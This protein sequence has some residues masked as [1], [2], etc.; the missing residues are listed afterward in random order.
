MEEVKL[1][2]EYFSGRKLI[3]GSEPW[4]H[5]YGGHQFGYFAGQL[6]D[7]RAISLGQYK[8]IHDQVWELQLKGSGRTPYSRFGDGYAVWRSSVR[9]FLC[10]E[11]FHALGIPTSRAA[12]MIATGKPVQREIMEPG[13]IVTRLAP[14]WIRF[15]SFELWVARQDKVNLEKLMKYTQT[16]FYPWTQDYVDL[17]QA[18]VDR[19]L[20]T[21]TQWQLIGWAHGV[22]NTD[23]ISIIGL[24]LDYGPFAFLDRFD[25][26]HVSNH[27][28]ELGRYTLRQQPKVMEW[29]L[30]R[31]AECFAFL[32]NDATPFLN[33]LQKLPTT[34]DTMYTQGLCK[35]LG[36][37]SEQPDDKEKFVTPFLALMERHGVDYTHFFRQLNAW[38]PV[39]PTPLFPLPDDF[40]LRYAHR[41]LQDWEGHG[42]GVWLEAKRKHMDGINPN[43]VFR[44]WMTPYLLQEVGDSEGHL[45]SSSTSSLDRWRR[46][47]QVL[48][49]PFREAPSSHSNSSFP[50]MAHVHPTPT[51][52]VDWNFF[53]VPPEPNQQ[54]LVC[55]CS[56]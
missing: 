48:R 47:F 41:L 2:V 4:S 55:G 12:C 35:K 39:H 46:V 29:N 43:F 7:G 30:H 9:E 49:E 52:E 1:F 27:S 18:I 54:D 50:Y 6:G 21:L 38:D 33:I 11:H 51:E 13:A 15:G 16:R 19:T 14:S 26:D 20:H 5:C 44:T 37:T 17:F 28:D 22:L 36:F 42:G 23:N 53:A 8:N 24:T 32:L 45:L 10:S 31:L 56:S 3:P 34:F 25:P 40:Y